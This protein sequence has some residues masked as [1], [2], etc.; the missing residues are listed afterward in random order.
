MTVEYPDRTDDGADLDPSS[1]SIRDDDA[2]AFI[3]EASSQVASLVASTLGPHGMSKLLQAPDPHED[4]TELVFTDSGREVLDTIHRSEGFNHP[5]SALFVD[6][7]ESMQLGVHD[8]TTTAVVLAAELIDHGLDLVEAGLHPQNVVIG[9][10]MATSRA[11]QVLDELDRELTLDDRSTL[12][13]V[14]STSMTDTMEAGVR[15]RYS[16]LVAEAVAEV[17]AENNGRI[18]TDDIKTVV[19]R[20]VPEDRVYRGLVVRQHKPPDPGDTELEYY[21]SPLIEERLNEVGVA[22]LDQSVN[23]EEVPAEFSAHR[24]KDSGSGPARMQ[25]SSRAELDQYRS[26][27]DA[28]IASTAR[29]ITNLGV[30][31]LISQPAV[32]DPFRRALLDAGI[33]VLDRIDTPISD[34]YRIARTTGATVVEHPDDLTT[35]HVGTADAVEQSEVEKERWTIIEGT[36]RSIYSITAAASMDASVD[37]RER[38]LKDAI[39]VTALAASDRRV[40]PGAGASAMAVATALRDYATSIPDREQLAVDAFADALDALLTTMI[41][42]AGRDHTAGITS[43]RTAH[44]GAETGPAPIGIDL[45]TGEPI[46]TWDAGVIEP[47]RVFSQAIETARTT[48]ENLLIVDSVLFPDVDLSDFD[49]SVERR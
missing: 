29:E 35:E 16:R 40:A 45:S 49:P 46:D 30:G 4:G 1:W 17:V 33:E 15:D 43:L 5:V 37:Q 20:L 36:E 2:R 42:N 10:A 25:V 18:V 26:Q 12:Q 28:R 41:R 47:R 22:V 38:I 21:D 31:L 14:A 39:E 7:V 44:D 24:R 11:G 9:Y 34:I 8:G 13:A 23:F 19:N 6:S 27:R 48:A 3:G 32:D